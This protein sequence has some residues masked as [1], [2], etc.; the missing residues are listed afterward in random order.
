[1]ARKDFAKKRNSGSAASRTTR[2]NAKSKSAP[3]KKPFPLVRTVISLAFLVGFVYVLWQL[4]SVKPDS[5]AATPTNAS[6][7][8]ASQPSSTVTKPVA[9][10]TKPKPAA[11]AKTNSK[12][13]SQNTATPTTPVEEQSERFG[14][15]E[16]LPDSE[17]DTANVKPYKSTPKSAKSKHTYVL[18]AGSFQSS[19]DAD[20]LRARLILEGLPSVRT[21]RVTNSNGSI[22][23]Q[24]L[25]GPFENRSMLS[26]AE[27]RLVRMNIQPLVRQ[28]D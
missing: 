18:Q 4:T 11:Q 2:S 9:K 21:K 16:I 19:K 28:I 26:K 27:D 8:P 6:A 7:K 12:T 3:V 10:T 15:Y 23:Y 14:F 22:W 5:S 1:M 25:A 17:V 24:V 13:S 20:Q